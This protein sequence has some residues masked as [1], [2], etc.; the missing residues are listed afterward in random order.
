[1]NIH[2]SLHEILQAKD[3]L[4]EMFYEHFLEEHPEVR[5]LFANVDFKR[6]RILLTTALMVVERCYAHPTPAVEQ[7]LQYLGTKHNE[8]HVPREA[9]AKWAEVM[10]ATMREFHGDEWSE[11][12]ER[13]WRAAIDQACEL[14]FQGYEERITV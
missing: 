13:E 10:I 8:F 3:R 14:M 9:Y 6:Q 11:E 2:K 4:A 7:Y 1:M 5:P 12:L